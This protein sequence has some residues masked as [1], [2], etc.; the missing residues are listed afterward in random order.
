MQVEN[1]HQ[2]NPRYLIHLTQE[3]LERIL[4][5]STQMLSPI[6]YSEAKPL[7]S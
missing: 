4:C 5:M 1:E 7:Q 3:G 6:I 2:Y